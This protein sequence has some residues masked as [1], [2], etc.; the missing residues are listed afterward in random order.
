MLL[1][2]SRS[3]PC[4]SSDL[5]K[6][7]TTRKRYYT[8][9]VEKETQMARGRRSRRTGGGLRAKE[10]DEGGTRKR[11]REQ[12][13]DE[14]EGER[15]SVG[16]SDKEKKRTAKICRRIHSCGILR[17]GDVC[18]LGQFR[19]KK[20]TLKAGGFITGPQWGIQ[21]AGRERGRAYSIGKEELHIEV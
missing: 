16:R 9:V 15:G 8:V 5:F 20:N 12:C 1:A 6:S 2:D 7:D 13:D 14:R 17:L 21:R 4:L 11:E 18:V 3:T 19:F 10:E